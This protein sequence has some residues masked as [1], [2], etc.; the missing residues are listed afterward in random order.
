MEQI[1]ER[2]LTEGVPPGVV[3]R[4]FALQE[5]VV[6]EASRVLKIKRYNTDDINDYMEQLQWD[7]LEYARGLIARGSETDKIRVLNTVLGKQVALQARR[8]PESTRR[9]QQGLI[10]ALAKMRTGGPVSGTDQSE[11]VVRSVD[12]DA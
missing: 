4:V 2:L 7:S 12:E 3:A 11:Y 9:N 6:R 8:T 10:D 1:V 5:D